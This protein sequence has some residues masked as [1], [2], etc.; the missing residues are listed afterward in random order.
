MCFIKEREICLWIQICTSNISSY[1]FKIN[2]YI[3]VHMK[4]I[5]MYRFKD[6]CHKTISCMWKFIL[7]VIEA[8]PQIFVFM[9]KK[10]DYSIFANNVIKTRV[11]RICISSKLRNKCQCFQLQ[12]LSG[13]YSSQ[14]TRIHYTANS[15][16]SPD[17]LTQMCFFPKL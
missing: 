12:K 16:C 9:Y 6:L 10:C 17:H 1:Q 3:Y 13:F 11:N 4:K 14:L 8:L 2:I 5:Y 15:M 7:N